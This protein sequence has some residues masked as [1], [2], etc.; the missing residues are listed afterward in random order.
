MLFKKL[1]VKEFVV[2][3]IHCDKCK[4]NVELT[5]KSIE[6]VKKAKADAKTGKTIIKS[7]IEI[8]EEIIK[9]KLDEAGFNPVF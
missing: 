2:E 7:T 8:N 9:E 1:I 4:A 3:G 5:L 6:G